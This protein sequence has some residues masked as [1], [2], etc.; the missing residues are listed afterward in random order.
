MIDQ[1]REFLRCPLCNAPLLYVEQKGK[2]DFFRVTTDYVIVPRETGARLT[3]PDNQPI[4]CT[5]CSW[6]GYI[7]ELVEE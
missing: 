4:W 5:S 1:E 7:T 6:Q 3:L 2:L